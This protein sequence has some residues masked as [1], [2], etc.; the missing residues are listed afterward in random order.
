M[1]RP[2]RQHCHWH[3]QVSYAVFYLFNVGDWHYL[4]RSDHQSS[5]VLGPGKT[6]GVTNKTYEAQRQSGMPR[7][8]PTLSWSKQHLSELIGRLPARVQPDGNAFPRG[9]CTARRI[10]EAMR[11]VAFPGEPSEALWLNVNF[12]PEDCE[13]RE[14][15]EI[16]GWEVYMCRA[17]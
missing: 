3:T 2:C 16:R 17:G 5:G 8:A 6:P 9:P 13:I 10:Q 7:L 4:A 15:Q 11:L 1:Q 14:V 12:E